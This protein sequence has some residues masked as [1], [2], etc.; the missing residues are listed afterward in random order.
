MQWKVRI[1]LICM[2]NIVF[3][4]LKTY[5]VVDLVICLYKNRSY[6]YIQTKN[7]DYQLT[8]IQKNQRS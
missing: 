2:V 3:N 4:K 1:C 6:V 5:Y 8:K 7:I